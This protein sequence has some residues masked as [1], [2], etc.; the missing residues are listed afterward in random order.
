MCIHNLQFDYDFPLESC[1]WS[2]RNKVKNFQ[3]TAQTDMKNK[4]FSI[5]TLS[6][7]LSLP[8][9]YFEEISSNLILLAPPL[10]LFKNVLWKKCVKVRH[11]TEA[12]TK[13]SH[14]NQ[15]HCSCIFLASKINS[16]FCLAIA[17]LVF[18]KHNLRSPWFST[19]FIITCM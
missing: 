3:M 7:D 16:N 19:Y 13:C 8:V 1:S 9:S 12:N 11:K 6:T 4:R 2:L 10:T 17:L 15:E 18:A 14:K 5:R